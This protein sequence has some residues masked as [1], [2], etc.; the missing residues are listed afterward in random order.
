LEGAALGPA[1]S[2]AAEEVWAAGVAV[3]AAAAAGAVDI[4][5]GFDLPPGENRLPSGRWHKPGFF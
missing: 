5:G 2:A 4:G 3:E 1:A